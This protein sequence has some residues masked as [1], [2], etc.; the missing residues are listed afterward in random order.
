MTDSPQKSTA[1]GS[2]LSNKLKTFHQGQNIF[3]VGQPSNVA[4]M[5]KSGKVAI[6]SVV[7]NKR[8]VT[9]TLG[10]GQIFGE[11]G[12]ISGEKRTSNADAL[13]FCE[14]L[15]L[16]QAVMHTLLLKS[17]RPVQIITGYLVNRVKALSERITDRPSG[18]VYLSACQVLALLHKSAQAS[19]GGRGKS[20]T[21]ELSYVEI[22]KSIKEIL[23]ISQLEIDELFE[24]LEKM[25]IIEFV[26][27]KG[28]F[29]KTDPL[30]GTKKKTTDYIKD[31][32]VYI[33]DVE[34]LMVVARNMF[35]DMPAEQFSFLTDLE[36]IDIGAFADMVQST[37]EMIYKKLAYQEIPPSLFF[38]HKTGISSFAKEKGQDFFQ[39]ARKPRMK[40]SE[41]ESIDDIEGID[42]STLEDALS[43]LSFH[44][45]PLLVSLAGEGAKEKI[46]NNLSRKMV[47]IVQ[48][49]LSANSHFD[50]SAAVDAEEE[51]IEII[52]EIKGIRK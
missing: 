1:K 48:D 29:Y 42:D 16:D 14:V 51:F 17:P 34:K 39:R 9:A 12:V 21:V 41:L 37:P 18:N 10:T 24:R 47:K 33:P 52:K 5:I 3:R 31:R 4:Y 2:A 32:T 13:E 28:A 20:Q 36:F 50:E 25:T 7:N 11:M 15:V 43:Q 49:E 40:A 8:I 46:L 35:K 19:P 26:D 44:K 27:I 6:Y 45:L 22:S 38:F 23:L 30:L